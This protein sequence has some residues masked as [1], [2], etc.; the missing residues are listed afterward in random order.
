MK[1]ICRIILV[2]IV[3][4]FITVLTTS[5]KFM[6]IKMISVVA[7]GVFGLMVSSI[8]EFVDTHGQGLK[9]WVD[10]QIRYRN[11][12]IRLS[13]SYLFRIE[14]D[15][16]YLLVKGH[17]MNNQFQPVGGVYKVYDEGRSFLNQIRAVSD[18]AMGN[19]DET[20]DL[21]I[22]IKGKNYFKF[23]DWFESMKDREYDPRREFEEELIDT[24]ILPAKA[25]QKLKYRKVWEHNEGVLYSQPLGKY[26]V[27]YADIFEIKL[28]DYQKQIIRDVVRKNYE[29]ICLASIDEIRCRRYNNSVTMNL[30]N[31]TSWI[32]GEE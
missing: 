29:Q 15:G 25:F 26:E 11:K 31:N 9:T 5:S 10:T 16:K 8:Y 28:T 12:N 20:D 14:V 22:Q 18:T 2:G 27:L 17:R 30:G 24:D 6:G 1:K 13:F 21:R 7:S 3:S 23:W 19:F 4:L 32:L